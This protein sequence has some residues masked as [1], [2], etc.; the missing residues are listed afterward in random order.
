M[1][2]SAFDDKSQPPEPDQVA[3]KIGKRASARWDELDRHLAAEFAPLSREWK[4]SGKAYGWSLQMKRKK[5]AVVYMTPCEGF[6]RASF[7]IGEKAAEAA[8]AGGL[9]AE[10]L[11]LIDSAQRYAEG[12]AVRVEVRTKKDLEIVKKIAAV[13]MAN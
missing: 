7:A 12:R 3:A 13:K 2:F 11:E 4:Y 8:H 9:P 1:A 10:A 6:F 5:R